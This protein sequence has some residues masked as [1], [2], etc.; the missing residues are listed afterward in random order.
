MPSSLR[1]LALGAATL[2]LASPAVSA[3]LAQISP[4]ALAVAPSGADEP[5]ARRRE[6]RAVWV[7]SVGNIDWPSRVGLTTAEQQAELITLLDSA[8]SLRLNAVI[9]QVRP[10]AD[11][12]Y[13]SKIEPWSEFLTGVEGQ[14]PSPWYDPLA[15]A[16]REA[17]A[18]GLELHAWFNPYRAGTPGQKSRHP[19]SHVSRAMRSV[20]RK[21]G[22][23]LWMDP[24]EPSV[25]R[26]TVRV[27]LD[28]VRRYDIDGVH[29]DDYFYPYQEYDRRGAVID[30]PDARS[31]KR[32][33]RAGGRLARDDWRRRNVDDLVHELY[34]GIH[35]IK[36][37]VKFGVSPFGIWRPGNP[38]SIAG[39]DAYARLYAD[40]RRWLREGWV[41]Y[42]TPQLYWP[43]ADLPHSYTT[44]LGWWVEQNVRRRHIWPGNYT[45][46]A[47]ANGES[48]WRADDIVAQIGVTRA[49]AGATGNVH[50]SGRAFLENPDSLHEKLRAGPYADLA[51]VPASPWLGAT[52]PL[53]P[54]LT[55]QAATAV[56][57][58]GQPDT[59]H[60]PAHL[61]LRS[62]GKTAPFLWAVRARPDSLAAWSTQLLPGATPKIPIP[63]GAHDVVVTAIDR[64]GNESRPSRLT[65]PTP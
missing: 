61:D 9:L 54:R 32:Y 57:S 2:L 49:Q 39:Y 19:A 65:L 11:A 31:W 15:F 23:Y 17:H 46:K 60:V 29:L 55:L 13:A 64:V 24:G 25:R 63:T 14:A 4:S 5:P 27:V 1:L 21:Y 30:F 47:G 7:A 53:A 10:A 45:N 51:L 44:L 38:P 58:P 50:F 12:L 43:I 6:F 33:R 28:V 42:Y 36:P 59:L 18:R 35:R 48:G 26:R 56:A 62:G 37:L 34:A 3:A 20:V 41:D 8:V 22:P 40:S 16:V 52:R